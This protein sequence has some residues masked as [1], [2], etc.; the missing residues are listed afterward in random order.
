MHRLPLLELPGLCD[1]LPAELQ[2]QTEDAV[3]DV[4]D[5][6][7]FLRQQTPERGK[8]GPSHLHILHRISVHEHWMCD[9]RS[10]EDGSVEVL[11][12]RA[13]NGV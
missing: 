4:H 2:D 12:V 3:D 10:P 1:Q 8:K 11:G 9:E 13:V 6:G 7:G 5:R